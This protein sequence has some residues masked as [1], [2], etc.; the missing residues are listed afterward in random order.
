L[1]I[2]KVNTVLLNGRGGRAM[3]HAVDHLAY[4]QQESAEH[5]VNYI[6]VAVANNFTDIRPPRPARHS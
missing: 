4:A 3:D 2:L 5:H 1:Y 6:E